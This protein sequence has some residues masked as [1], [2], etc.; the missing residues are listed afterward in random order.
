MMNRIGAGRT[1]SVRPA[2]IPTAARRVPAKPW[3]G[4]ERR[5]NAA[6]CAAA[7]KKAASAGGLSAWG[8]K[9]GIPRPACTKVPKTGVT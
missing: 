7:N 5:R 6:I 4:G 1:R 2:G 8:V 9:E 3:A